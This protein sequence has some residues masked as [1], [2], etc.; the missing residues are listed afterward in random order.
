MFGNNEPPKLEESKNIS[1]VLNTPNENKLGFGLAQRPVQMGMTFGTPIIKENDKQ[2]IN[3]G[4]PVQQ[5]TPPVVQVPAE[6]T[7]QL[8][9]A[10]PLITVGN[11]YNHPHDT[12]NTAVKETG[13]QFSSESEK[14]AVIK[15]LINDEINL[16]NAE[17]E[18]MAMKAKSI[19]IN[20]RIFEYH[21]FDI[22]YVNRF[23]L[24]WIRG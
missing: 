3:F 13:G 16:F 22:V 23:L 18:E 6:R 9:P 8:E 1:A 11:T 7:V 10:K 4:K 19:T 5:P 12:G 20:V 15:K 17:L 2:P 24:D 14:N 21:Y